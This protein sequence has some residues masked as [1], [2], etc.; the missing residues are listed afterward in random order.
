MLDKTS[1]V[2]F[3]ECTLQLPDSGWQLTD[4]TIYFNNHVDVY[5]EPYVEQSFEFGNGVSA[6][7]PDILMLSG[8]NLGNH[9]YIYTHFGS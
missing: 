2:N 6:N 9:G 3:D 4:G 1:Q 8:A 7:D 5:G